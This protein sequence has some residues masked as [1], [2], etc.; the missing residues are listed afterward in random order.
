MRRT[1]LFTALLLML[2]LTACRGQENASESSV[3]PA[4]V[5]GSTEAAEAAEKV[6]EAQ[7]YRK[8]AI[9][10]WQISNDD[11]NGLLI[12]AGENEAYIRVAINANHDFIFD[13]DRNFVSKG[14]TFT[15]EDYSFEDGVFSVSYNDKCIVEMKKTDGIDD[16]FGEFHLTGGQYLDLYAKSN[17]EGGYNFDLYK[18]DL[19]IKEN[20]TTVWASSSLNGFEL[21]P[22]KQVHLGEN[23]EAQES[24]Y[25]VEGDKMYITT[26]EGNERELTRIG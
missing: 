21:R 26:S 13:A 23:G 15:K 19:V 22:D 5:T 3:S 17:E 18:I 9:G 25:R 16:I 12:I 7:D 24:P 6:T 11:E 10:T 2:S 1:V 20:D 8:A 4:A 14:R